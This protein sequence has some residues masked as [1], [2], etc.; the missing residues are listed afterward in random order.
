MRPDVV[1]AGAGLIGMACALELAGRGLRLALVERGRSGREAS[2]AAAG[3]LAAHDPENPAALAAL[4]ELS[5]AL[6]PAFLDSLQQ[7]SGQRVPLETAWTL[8]AAA[9]ETTDIAPTGMCPQGF[10]RVHEW[11]VDPRK[12]SG[13]ALAAVRLS[14]IDLR[15]DTAVQSYTATA[16]DVNVRLSDGTT[17]TTHHVVDCTGAWHAHGVH[18]TK[19]QMVRVHAPG[20][21]SA[22]ALGNV[23]VRDGTFYMVPR[24]D[25]SVIIGA[26]VED[27]GFDKSVYTDDLQ[28][29]RQRAAQLLPT[30]AHA[31]ELERW[32]GLRP[33]TPDHLPLIGSVPGVHGSAARVVVA[34]GH[35]RN[36]I[37]LA[38][39][40]AHVVARLLLGEVPPINLAAFAPHRFVTTPA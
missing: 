22:G 15:E 28:Q 33:G 21:L 11:S 24:L 5:I 19:G 12:L 6:Y 27:A 14:G 32:A 17:L 13:A 8:E 18:P 9:G 39:A 10:R 31:P 34:A 1:I 37:L 4:A 26:T 16:T 29:L 36:G 40:T 7:H 20:A 30:L 23:V 3:M 2:W 25:G 38:P 35:F